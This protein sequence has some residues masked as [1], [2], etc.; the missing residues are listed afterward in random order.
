MSPKPR[1]FSALS[2]PVLLK[3]MPSPTD[4]LRKPQVAGL[5]VQAIGEG[6][7]AAVLCV[8]LPRPIVSLALRALPLL[9]PGQAALPILV[10][11]GSG[12]LHRGQFPCPLLVG[13][14]AVV[15]VPLPFPV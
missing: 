4:P 12:F 3:P 9:Q 6:P 8:L 2:I 15:A 7:A 13:R 5:P 10:Q 14:L 1:A 11:V